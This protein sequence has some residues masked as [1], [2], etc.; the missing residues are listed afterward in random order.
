MQVLSEKSGVLFPGRKAAGGTNIPP[1]AGARRPLLAA[2]PGNV[3]GR[4]LGMRAI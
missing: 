1:S 4:W 3:D 2:G